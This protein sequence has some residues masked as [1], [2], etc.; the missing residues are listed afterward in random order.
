MVSSNRFGAL[1]IAVVFAA[2]GCSSISE[3][4]KEWVATPEAAGDDAL[5]IE[6]ES[7]EL[8]VAAQA[9]TGS[10]H[11][12]CSCETPNVLVDMILVN[13]A[14]SRTTCRN[15]CRDII[16]TTTSQLFCINANF[17]TFGSRTAVASLPNVPPLNPAP[18]N[19]C[20]W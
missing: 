4:G 6:D 12:A 20:G 17:V 2:I 15:Y 9:L 10:P 3:D 13:N 7:G 11:Q 18:G 8:G 16:G 14:W 19:D 5:Q 1:T